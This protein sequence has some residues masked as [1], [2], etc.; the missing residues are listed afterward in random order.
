MLNPSLDTIKLDFT[1]KI[2]RS[3]LVPSITTNPN[4]DIENKDGQLAHVQSNFY[5][6]QIDTNYCNIINYILIIIN[7]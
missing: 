2:W 7:F 3:A 1:G 4:K 6:I 5:W